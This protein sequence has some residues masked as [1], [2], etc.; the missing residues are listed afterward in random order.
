MPEE[1][2]FKAETSRTRAQIADT[3][4][5]AADEIETGTVTLESETDT[6][7]VDVPETAT[8]EMELER[9]T[10]SETGTAYYELE[11]ELSWTD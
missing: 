9:V 4:R 7:P 6:H 8:F 1:Q 3:L 10:D 2:L 11:Y 5:E